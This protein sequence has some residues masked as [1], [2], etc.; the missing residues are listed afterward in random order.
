MIRFNADTKTFNLILARSHYVFQVDGNGRLVH[1]TWGPR[2]Q[3]AADDSD[4]IDGKTWYE[5]GNFGSMN[6]QARPD[7]FLTYGDVSHS[8]V[9]LK[10]NFAT[11]PQTMQPYEAP[12]LPIRDVCLVYVDHEI[13]TD[14]APGFAAAHGLPT[15]VSTPRQTL[16]VILQDPEQPLK[17][18]LCYRLTP[19][20]DILERWC[21]LEN[22]GAVPI[23]VEQLYFAVWHV[24]N[25]RYELTAVSGA[26][27]R[28]FMTE[29]TL[30]P[31]GT[32]ILEHRTLQ[33]GHQTNPFFLLNRPGQ[34]WEASGTVYFGQLAYSGAWRLSFESMHNLNMRVHGGYNPVD[35]QLVLAPGATHK[36]PAMIAGVAH[37]GW[38]GA[39]RRL[40]AHLR[41]RV[42]P[43]PP[44]LPALRP[45][46]YNGWEAAYF[47]L[48]EQ[49]QIELARKAAE[50]GVELFCV[51]DGWFG[52]RRHDMA[53]LGDWVVSKDVFPNGLQQLIDEVHRLGMSFGLW[54]EPEMVNADSDLYRAHPEWILHFPGRPRI[55]YRNQLILDLGRREVVEYLFDALDKLLAEYEI[56]F[57]KWDM[58]RYQC[59]P[60]SV[61]GKAIWQ[62][63]VAGVYEMMDRLR[64][65]YP[66][67]SI[68]SCS[69]GGG[70][71][72]AGILARTDQVWTSDNT[73]ALTRVAIQEGFSLA[74]PARAMEAWV[75]HRQNH[76]TARILE[77]STRFHVAMRGVLGIGSNLNELDGRDLQEYRRFITFYKQM[78]HVV[79]NGDL[80]R[81]QRLEEF[82]TSVVQYV[83]PDGREAVYSVVVVD[84]KIGQFRPAPPLKQLNSS[85]TYVISD[86]HGQEVRRMTGYELMTR[87]MPGHATVGIGYGLTLYL[88][89][90][91]E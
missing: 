7:E 6:Q 11:L 34:A 53:G 66:Q 85:A 81:L 43:Q 32:Y 41:E 61:V 22:V 18:I 82:G 90:V 80:Y 21:E 49:G 77:T 31:I 75:T 13:V 19:E 40:H 64:H 84:H 5:Q 91:R 16:R 36:T 15:A 25:G 44:Q 70:R 88:K 23:E 33:T 3:H 78:R 24:E 30:L 68:Q 4:L 79:Q 69:G 50:M 46:L 62:A 1:L 42:L 28:E 12:L 37:N 47:N 83:L 39:S 71:I 86:E 73:D 58:N 26:W 89:Q 59:P 51:D 60:G 14:A 52:G 67:L 54:V 29:R 17:V 10:A 76:Q 72:D 87:G 74:Y 57:F 45:V 65:K 35:F 48:S 38:G 55:E 63:H 2:G 27:A 56:A 20:H 8:E 9:S